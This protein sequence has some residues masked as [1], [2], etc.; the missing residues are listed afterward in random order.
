MIGTEL[1]KRQRPTQPDEATV[2][3]IIAWPAVQTIAARPER[4]RA[5]VQI[6]VPTG[7]SVRVGLGGVVASATNGLLLDTLTGPAD[8]TS[9][10]LGAISI[11]LVAGLPSVTVCDEYAAGGISL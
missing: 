7:G 4:I 8:L 3:R 2:T 1:A 11:A 10:N 5:T 6:E 9:D